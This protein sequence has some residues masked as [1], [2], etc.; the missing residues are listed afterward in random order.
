[1]NKRQ[2]KI[3]KLYNSAD[4][5][6]ILDYYGSPESVRNVED[7]IE[8]LDFI[9]D[10]ITLS[11]MANDF[12]LASKLIHNSITDEKQKQLYLKL[13]ETNA[14]IDETINI[15][16]LSDKYSFLGNL[17]ESIIT[18]I[19]VQQRLISLSAEKLELFKQLF[20]KVKNEVS[21]PIPIIT[22]LLRH[23]GTSPHIHQ[24]NDSNAYSSL[25]SNLEEQLKHGIQLSESDKEKLLFIYTSNT[26]WT[27][28]SIED[29][30]SF[31][32]KNSKDMLEIDEMINNER[33]STA[34]NITNIQNA[35]LWKSYGISLNEAQYIVSKY[36]AGN[37]KITD[38]NRDTM[39][40]IF[41]S[42]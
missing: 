20:N 21:N 41:K 18:D 16:L 36:K 40:I 35:L 15:E 26:T 11:Q 27:V 8:Q 37:I 12:E 4:E 25:N 13:K 31:G 23:L 29:L 32:E 30:A 22:N 2:E 9:S 42:L 3:F 10:K 6:E 17:L 24:Y 19:E 14:D 5:K 34:K 1:M 33:S 28:T 38:N 7:I 39:R